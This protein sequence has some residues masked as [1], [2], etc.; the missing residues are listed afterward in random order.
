M[1]GVSLCVT[2]AKWWRGRA[3]GNV[4]DTHVSP[5]PLRQVTSTKRVVCTLP[6]RGPAHVIPVLIP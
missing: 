5:C 4:E 3:D 6:G 2:D 1:K